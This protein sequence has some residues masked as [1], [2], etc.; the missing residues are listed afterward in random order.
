[1]AAIIDALI[2]IAFLIAVL[3]GILRDYRIWPFD[4]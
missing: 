1:M 4:Q 3:L 2:V